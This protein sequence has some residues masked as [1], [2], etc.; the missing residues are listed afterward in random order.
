MRKYLLTAVAAGAVIAATGSYADEAAAQKWIDEEFQPSA[1]TK[2]EQLA[3]MQ[4]F[5]DAAAPFAGLEI[6]VLSETIP[7]HTYESEVLAK[8]FFEITGIKVNH[9]LLGEGEVLTAFRV[10]ELACGER[11]ARLELLP[12]E[13][14]T[15]EKLH[16]AVDR[17]SGHVLETEVFDLLGNTTRVRFADVRVN[18]RPDAALFRFDAPEGVEVIELP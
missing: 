3:E 13:P 2:D 8:A 5:I 6:N 17:A 16:L 11:E 4:W 7:T 9:Q 10:R 12:R 18:T 15:Y 1:L 14:A